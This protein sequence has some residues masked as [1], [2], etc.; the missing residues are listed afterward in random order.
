MSIT[1]HALTNEQDVQRIIDFRRA[2]TTAENAND[3]P[4]VSDLPEILAPASRYAYRV[5]LWDDID[6]ALLAFGIVDTA[7]CNLYFYVQPEK[8]GSSLESAII[9]WA[10]VQMRMIGQQQ[11]K[12]VTLDISCW[13][14]DT[15]K[16][17]LFE[18]HGFMRQEEQTLR[19]QRS[20]TEPAP[21][22]QLPTGF[23]VRQ[24]Q[25]EQDIE[26]YVT[27]H[28]EAFG[29]SHMTIEHRLAIM[30]NP[31]YRPELDVVAVA[32]DSTFAAFCVCNINREVNE[33]SGQKEGEIG[34]IG[35]R[36]MYRNMGLGRA[37]LLEGLQRL[38]VCGIS[39]AVLGTTSSNINAIRLYEFV[40]F[41]V[42]SRVLW[43]T[44]SV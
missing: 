38:K 2:C 24:L 35:T 29:T 32:P 33:Q 16:M 9:T 15:R 11:N 7:F 13:G 17:A 31:N 42:I 4:T 5:Q 19:M 30:H 8:Q 12:Q 39:T 34:I 20:L 44:K 14:N 6:G 43:Y 36:P 23:I 3:Y 1:M 10:L 21:T 37:M 28:R 40:G 26:E 25:G 22:P 18:Q 41:R 27:L